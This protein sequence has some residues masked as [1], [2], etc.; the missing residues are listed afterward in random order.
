MRAVVDQ[1]LA[2]LVDG[3]VGEQLSTLA[4]LLLKN[5]LARL[6]EE[7]HAPAHRADF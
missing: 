3:V 4:L 6:L 7:P 5:A 2:P 1:Q